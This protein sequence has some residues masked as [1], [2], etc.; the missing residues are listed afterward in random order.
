M[1]V[2]KIH[3]TCRYRRIGHCHEANTL[4]LQENGLSLLIIDVK[5]GVH[6]G[7]EDLGIHAQEL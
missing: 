2:E 5:I 4:T 7:T 6:G 3:G 1:W